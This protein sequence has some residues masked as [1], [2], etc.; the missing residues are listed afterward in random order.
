VWFLV[1][2]QANELGVPQ[3]LRSSPF[4][5]IDLRHGLWLQPQ[6]RMPDYAE[7]IWA[8]ELGSRLLAICTGVT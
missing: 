6:C 2:S 7:C 1:I 8:P 5:K 4:E 3:M